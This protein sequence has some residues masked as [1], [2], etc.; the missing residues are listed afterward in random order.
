MRGMMLLTYALYTRFLRHGRLTRRTLTATV[1]QD[2]RLP[3]DCIVLID[4]DDLI[5]VGF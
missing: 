3:L 5:V 4:Y 1:L 2:R